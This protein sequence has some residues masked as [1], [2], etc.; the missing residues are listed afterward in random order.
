MNELEEAWKEV[1]WHTFKY[2]PSIYLEELSK[3]R[4]KENS[5]RQPVSGLRMKFRIS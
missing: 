1:V 5:S 2:Y 3:I 4:R